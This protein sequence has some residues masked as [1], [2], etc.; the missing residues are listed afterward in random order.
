[1]IRKFCR[2]LAVRSP[3]KQGETHDVV[4]FGTRRIELR[5]HKCQSHEADELH[6]L[7]NT[8][9][10]RVSCEA[11][12]VKRNLEPG[13]PQNTEETNVSKQII[14]VGN[15][16]VC[17]ESC[18][19]GYEEQIEEQFNAVGFMSLREDEGIVISAH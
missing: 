6:R 16:V 1:M 8:L 11:N 15:R 18:E 4:S 9:V 5:A 17:G 3:L 10:Q 7:A 12:I 2:A 14:A 13:R 19:V